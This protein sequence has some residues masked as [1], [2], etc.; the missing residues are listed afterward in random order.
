MTLIKANCKFR[1]DS[2]REKIY[3]LGNNTWVVYSIVTIAT[4]QVCPRAG[5][6]SPMTIK[7]GQSVTVSHGCHIPTM[8]HLIS[9]DELEEKEI[10]NS[11]LDWTMSLSQLFNH[12]DN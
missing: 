11:W 5:T 7:S 1:I 3:S 8:D 9:A 2:T 12:N 6:L 10:V 4:N